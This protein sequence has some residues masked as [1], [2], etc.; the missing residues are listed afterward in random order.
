MLKDIKLLKDHNG[1][2]KGAVVRVDDLRA[3]KM[4]KAGIGKAATRSV[5][6]NANQG[7]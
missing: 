6:P 1:R 3:A 7:A 2:K 4:I 5:N